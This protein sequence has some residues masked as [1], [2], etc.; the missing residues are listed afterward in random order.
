M[1]FYRTLDEYQDAF[2]PTPYYIIYRKAERIKIFTD[3]LW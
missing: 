1:H 2:R 3:F